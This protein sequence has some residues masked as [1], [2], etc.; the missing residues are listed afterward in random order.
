MLIK[1]G[2]NMVSSN[3]YSDQI[4]TFLGVNSANI[5]LIYKY[6]PGSGYT[7]ISDQTTNFEQGVG[8]WFKSNSEFTYENTGNNSSSPLE[9]TWEQGWNMI[10]TPFSEN[11]I[12]ENQSWK[13]NVDLIYGFDKNVG[14]QLKT[15]SDI[16]DSTQG[17]WF[18]LNASIT[19][20]FVNTSHANDISL[21]VFESNWELYPCKSNTVRVLDISY[22]SNAVR[23]LI[24]DSSGYLGVYISMSNAGGEEKYYGGWG[25]I[26]TDGSKDILKNTVINF[27][28]DKLD[29]QDYTVKGYLVYINDLIDQSCNVLESSDTNGDPLYSSVTDVSFDIQDH[30]THEYPSLLLSESTNGGAPYKL[31][32]PIT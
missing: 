7:H 30:G 18:K 26:V 19:H 23:S 20:T 3:G 25:P 15:K 11:L 2:W 16:L 32:I 17:Y 9:I 29:N 24:Q 8:Y 28:Q 4:Q 27:D 22:G 5:L 6:I 13:S 1:V 21:G 31:T 12:V 10:S 14:Y